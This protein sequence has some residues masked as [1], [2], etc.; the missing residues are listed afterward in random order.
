MIRPLLLAAP[1]ALALASPAFALDCSDSDG[2][3]FSG[4]FIVSGSLH[5]G[6]PYTEEEIAQFDAM[7]LRRQGVDVTRAERWAGCV[8]AWVRQPDGTERQQF[9]DPTTY[10]KLNLTLQR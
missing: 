7:T 5:F 1:I 8:R 6:K 2:I 3:R 4:N 9:F 10:E